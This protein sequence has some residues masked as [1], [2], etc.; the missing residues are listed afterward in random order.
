MPFT[1]RTTETPSLNRLAELEQ[2]VVV[3]KTGPSVT[4]GASNGAV[5]LVGEFLKGPFV[6]REVTSN[7]DIFSTFGGVSDRLSLTAAGVQDGSGGRYDGNG[8]VALL[9]KQFTRLVL[10]RVNTDM[11]T[12]DGGTTNAYVKFSVV[13]N[14]ADQDPIDSTKT[15]K[16]IVI[17]AGTRFG[18]AAAASAVAIVA[19][20]QDVVIPK[21]TTITAT[22][23]AIGFNLTQN[24]DG[25]LT[26][27]TSTATHG[28]TAFFVKG[29]T[30]ASGAMDTAIDT[31]IPGYLST[32]SNTALDLDIINAAGA[33]TACF[34][35]GTAAALLAAKNESLYAAAIAK[36]A[37][38]S[39]P[40]EDITVI[41]A[42]R[43]GT[44]AALIRTPLVQNAID[45]SDA[46]GRDRI[47]IVSG[48]RI[49]TATGDVATVSAGLTE[50]LSTTGPE[51]P[52][53]TDRKITAHPHVQVFS[54]DL[55]KL[56]TVGPDGFM[57]ATLSN[58]PEEKNPGARNPYIQS[59][60][61]Y[62]AAY[63]TTPLG[64]QDYVNFRSKGVAA[65]KKD[66]SVGW[67]FQSG[68]T[69]IDPAV[70]SSRA[71]IKRRRMAGF[72]QDTIAQIGAKYNKEPATIDRVDQLEGEIDSF[73]LSLKSPSN[74]ASQRIEDYSID[75]KSG[76][77][78]TLNAL[79][80]YVLIV[81]VRLL[82]S[83]DTL[84]FETRIGETVETDAT[85]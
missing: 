77:T 12:T 81:K 27:T 80:I 23:V 18:D 29:T 45:S 41:W 28:A 30:L 70:E 7:A 52:G 3:D 16:D 58:F 48:P 85:T 40:A 1:F 35:A 56:V 15:G 71:P 19:L 61:D 11:V 62:E 44:T 17:P 4:L 47:A 36:T 64:K 67:W 43:R 54:S 79:G 6:P 32:V 78:P 68:V 42:A 46:G 74:P 82:A 25:V 75:A 9:G 22:K 76:N 59:I 13:V 38:T 34:A 55:N 63:A 5:C 31:A 60:Q 83:M 8:M 26:L 73:L 20:S 69:S 10:Q 21:G 84:L 24:S 39:S 51:S 49:G 14:T 37:P 33:A 50:V 2:I 65:L 66:R 72:I 57:A 53:R